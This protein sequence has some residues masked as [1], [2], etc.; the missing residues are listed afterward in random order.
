MYIYI[1]IYT[2]IQ[3]PPKKYTNI[4]IYIHIYIHMH[5]DEWTVSWDIPLVWGHDIWYIPKQQT[6]GGFRFVMG[7]PPNHPS[8]G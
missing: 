2:L 6:Y 5:M 1:H 7:V 8:R 3:P 4:C